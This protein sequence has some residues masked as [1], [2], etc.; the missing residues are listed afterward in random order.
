MVSEPVLPVPERV[1]AVVP[2]AAPVFEQPKVNQSG[3]A[4]RMDLP[5]L[6][7]QGGESAVNKMGMMVGLVPLFGQDPSFQKLEAVKAL[8]AEAA[9]EQSHRGDP[10]VDLILSTSRLFDLLGL[11]VPEAPGSE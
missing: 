11:D 6:E 4:G 1:D 10:P 7:A 5:V 9:A 2:A 3:L 8:V